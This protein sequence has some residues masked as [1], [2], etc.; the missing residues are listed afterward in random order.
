MRYLL[1]NNIISIRV[2]FPVEG[3]DENGWNQIA[4]PVYPNTKY[5][6]IKSV[7]TSLSKQSVT[8]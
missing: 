3:G 2:N 1:K 7:K 6:V 5:H 8:D 4:Y